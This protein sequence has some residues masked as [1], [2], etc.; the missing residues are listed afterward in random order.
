MRL[1]K[2]VTMGGTKFEG[3]SEESPCFA[4]LEIR[5]HYYMGRDVG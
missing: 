3:R 2:S 1:S 5:R 4:N